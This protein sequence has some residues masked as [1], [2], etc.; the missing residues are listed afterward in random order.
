MFWNLRL[1]IWLLL[2]ASA[3]LNHSILSKLLN[4]HFSDTLVPR[5]ARITS[6][7]LLDVGSGLANVKDKQS[8]S[9]R[10]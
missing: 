9:L 8:E 5:R 2:N 1:V 3:S 7:S 6:E 10:I 4:G